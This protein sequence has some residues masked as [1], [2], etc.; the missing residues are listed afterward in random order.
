VHDFTGGI[1]PGGL[2]WTVRIPDDA[3]TV[4]SGG[5][6]LM[7][8]AHG[9]P[10]V[11]DRLAPAGDIAATVDLDI[12]WKGRRG[13]RDLSAASPPFAGRF[14]R[15]AAARGTFG[16]SEDGFGFASA[17]GHPVRSRFAELGSETNGVF[18]PAA[19]ECPRCA[20]QP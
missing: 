20:P 9:V 11:D 2:V 3:V 12:T 17:A 19:V 8:A 10:V 5:D 7:V 16:A 18:L 1:S 15:R 14:F 13:L 6:V 4:S